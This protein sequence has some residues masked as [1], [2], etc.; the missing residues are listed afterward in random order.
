MR[1]LRLG[2]YSACFSLLVLRWSA[3]VEDE[4]QSCSLEWLN[5]VGLQQPFRYL[6]VPVFLRLYR[7]WH[8]GSK[9]SVRKWNAF[10]A[11]RREL[12]GFQAEDETLS[13]QVACRSGDLGCR[14][15]TEL[16]TYMF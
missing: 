8:A 13:G 14:N 15:L 10:L 1:L 5:D 2:S 7:A 9:E 3:W 12:A 6:D 4:A 16:S 11:A